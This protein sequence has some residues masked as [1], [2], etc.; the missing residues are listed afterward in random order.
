M[1]GGPGGARPLPPGARTDDEPAVE[2]GA[3]AE[4]ADRNFGTD[5]PE[6]DTLDPDGGDSGAAVQ[7]PIEPEGGRPAPDDGVQEPTHEL[8]AAE[9]DADGEPADAAADPT[10]EI[11]DRPDIT[12]RDTE[13]ADAE[14]S[15]DRPYVDEAYVS[16]P[17]SV[18]VRDDP[19]GDAP[20]HHAAGYDPPGY[21]P[22][23]YDPP[24]YDPPGYDARPDQPSGNEPPGYE[25]RPDP[26]TG[27]YG[28]GSVPVLV[29]GGWEG[30][31]RRRRRQTLTFLGAFAAVIV[32]GF[33]AVLTYIGHIPWPFDG[34]VNTAQ[35][36]CTRSKPPPPKRISLRVYNGSTRKGLAK[37]VAAELK[38]FGFTIQDTGNDPLEAKL[39]TPIEIRHGDSGD[40]AAL[41]TTA[42]LNGKVRDVRDDR[43]A[44]SV[45]VVL[46]PSFT[47]VHTRREVSRALAALTPSLPLTC[48][49]G[50][51]PPASATPSR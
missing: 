30:V 14:P 38:A 15:Y 45:D 12:V 19:W 9:A 4:V 11:T 51:S 36:V 27:Q 47:R 43:Q 22:P 1:N 34:K 40:L 21:D 31:R 10:L 42:Y 18:D 7:D 29:E 20:G 16:P 13:D 2:A 5:S 46:G 37:Q 3:A 26:S 41:T 6:T 39:R 49:P 25:P 28:T 23:G 44:D 24:G 17:P 48:P 50:A 32:V 35:S 33:L 8:A